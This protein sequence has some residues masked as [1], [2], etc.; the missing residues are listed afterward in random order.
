MRLLF[1]ESELVEF[2]EQLPRARLG[3]N[4]TETDRAA[5]FLAVFNGESDSV[6][7]QRVLAQ[8]MDLCMPAPSPKIAESHGRL[9]FHE[10]MRWIG[11][12]IMRSFVITKVAQTVER[13]KGELEN[14]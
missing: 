6:R 9:A 13:K 8:I 2:L 3:A 12:Q 7:G 1:N 10:G 5:D 14:V 11:S 4:Y